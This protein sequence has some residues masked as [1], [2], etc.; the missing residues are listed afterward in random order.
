MVLLG[1][2]PSL[3]R[4]KMRKEKRGMAALFGERGGG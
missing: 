4:N 3:Y 2:R 1:A